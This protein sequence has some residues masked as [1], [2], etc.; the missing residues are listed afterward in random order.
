MLLADFLLGATMRR[1]IVAT[2]ERMDPR[3]ELLAL[4]P[5]QL[6]EAVNQIQLDKTGMLS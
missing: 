5:H 3:A 1:M 4:K 2:E 6:T